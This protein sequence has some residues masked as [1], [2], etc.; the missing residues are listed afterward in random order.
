[1][2][3]GGKLL[4]TSDQQDARL[5][6]FTAAGRI[7]DKPAAESADLAPE[8]STPCVWG[9]LILGVHSGLLLLDPAAPDSGSS[10]KTLW[11]DD[12]EDC[13]RGVCHA[14]VSEDRALVLCE[15]GQLLLLAADRKSCTI[16]DRVKLC[17]RTWVHPALA[18]GRLY[19]R[20]QA[21]VYCY[22]MPAPEPAS[23]RD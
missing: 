14:I 18:N 21:A 23:Q 6:G 8:I 5:L 17:G 10:L 2:A 15:D 16:L 19:V 1:M 20:D 4:L 13:L 11:L 12:K 7:V 3:V 22:D 9:G